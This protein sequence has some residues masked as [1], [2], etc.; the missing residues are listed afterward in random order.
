MDYRWVLR[1]Y[2]L[3]LIRAFF[4]LSELQSGRPGVGRI[5]TRAE[6]KFTT[7]S[8]LIDT[9]LDEHS[10][11][12]YTSW[13]M[14]L[15]ASRRHFIATQS[16]ISD[17]SWY[18]FMGRK[19]RTA[20]LWIVQQATPLIIDYCPIVISN[21]Y[22]N[23]ESLLNECNNVPELICHGASITSC[24]HEVIESCLGTNHTLFSEVV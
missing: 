4:V 11:C 6:H 24:R 8:L 7:I 2:Q 17:E 18:S 23:V 12:L 19:S 13:E 22:V 21:T 5:N 9:H 20:H 14:Y 1:L 10:S 16:C 3:Q 15:R